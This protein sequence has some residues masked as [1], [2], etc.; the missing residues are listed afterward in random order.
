MFNIQGD[1]DICMGTLSKAVG[2]VGGYVAGSRKLI[3][4][5]KNRAR[6]FIFD[7]SCL[8]QL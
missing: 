1:I 4:F 2:S 3:D 7:T 6:A 5:L 8:H